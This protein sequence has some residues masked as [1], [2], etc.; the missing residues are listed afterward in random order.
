MRLQIIPDMPRETRDT[1]FLLVVIAWVVAPM[2][3]ELPL[4]CSALSVLLMIWRGV[5]AWRQQA[6]PSRWWRVSLVFLALLA[7][8]LSF[9][10]V[11]G[12]DAG[13]TLI[14]VLLALK[15][16]ELRARRDA[17]VVFFL[18]F[19]LML[20]NFFYSQS[21]LTAMGMLIGLLGLLTA[22]INAHMPVSPAPLKHSARL[23]AGMT[24]LGAPVMI[25]LF[26]LFPR[27][28]PLWGLPNDALSAKSGLSAE[29]Q[30]GT[31]ASLA[32]DTSVAFRVQFETPAPPQS[33]LYFRGPVLSDFDGRNWRANPSYQSAEKLGLTVQGPEIRYELTLQPHQQAWLLSL[34]ATP[35]APDLGDKRVRM[36]ADLQWLSPRGVRTVMRYQAQAYTRFQYGQSLSKAA[37]KP[38]L[39]LPK[40]SNPRTVQWAQTL[41]AQ[42]PPDMQKASSAPAA[43][44]WVQQAMQTL[45]NDG[46]R[47]TLQPGRFGEHSADEF[48]FDRK[49]GF[50]EHI[51]SSFVVMMRALGVPARIVT[52]Y[53]GAEQNTLDDF[54]TVRQSDAHAW[55]E[56]W[57]AD[58]GW[59]R[60]DPTTAVAPERTTG[61]E[62]QSSG[63][64]G[65]TQAVFG[66]LS[67]RLTQRL[68][69]LWD[70][71]NNSWNQWVL[72]YEQGKQLQLLALLGFDSPSWED[73]VTLLCAVVV[74]SSLAG[75]GL[76][77]WQRHKQAPWLRLLEGAR[78]RLLGAGLQVPANSTPRQMA[79]LLQ[80]LTKARAPESATTQ[81]WVDWFLRLEA[82]RY[83]SQLDAAHQPTLATL[84]R[85]LSQLQLKLRLDQPTGT[86]FAPHSP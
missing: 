38:Y 56:V 24:L 72:N 65:F 58:V 5:L 28:A 39:A 29:M 84:R 11:F 83:G 23:A 85:D 30:V 68:R 51:A 86:R 25:I 60:V 40:G 74:A 21:L 59:Q 2:Y 32:L 81:R 4:W 1:L 55:V 20:T 69:L 36:G 76:A 7:T 53:Q 8:L 18:S 71:T 16:L 15:T 66:N 14:V 52:G 73:L 77:S 79:A 9:K 6:M 12:R 13:V 44:F 47:Y 10:T 41:Q 75:A 42:A 54:W 82:L 49:A 50:C 31:M 22:L 27:M 17:F 35:K 19:F 3:S 67:P 61:A 43:R 80:T 26:M 33:Q 37:L 45:R 64:G 62:R 48:W 34:D 70:A 57:L 63:T 78:Q 46:Y